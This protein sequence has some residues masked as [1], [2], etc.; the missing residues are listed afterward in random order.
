MYERR[1]NILGF[2]LI[3]ADGKVPALLMEAVDSYI[4]G[5]FYATIALC[6]MTAERL[7]Y[8]FIDFVDIRIGEKLLNNKQKQVLY[9]LPFSSLVDFFWK[10][11]SFND[12]TKG[13]MFNISDIR[14]RHIHPTMVRPAED[15]INI[16]N[17]LCKVLEEKLS[18]FQ[19]YEIN[20][21]KL[22][23]KR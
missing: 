15:A 16:L 12:R 21:G 13:L 3:M 17:L 14:N 10:I 9:K 18:I 20:D 2:D 11:G 5:N 1:K 7:C 23:L 22:V 6:G 8:D 19:F 4:L